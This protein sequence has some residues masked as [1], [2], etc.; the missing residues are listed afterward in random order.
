MLAKKEMPSVKIKKSERTKAAI[1]EAA[2]QLFAAQGYDR[3]TIREVAAA[4]EI[5]PALVMRYFGSKEELF[6][7]VAEPDLR[8]PDLTNVD[9]RD[10]GESLVRHFL[11]LWEGEDSGGGMP[12]LLRSAASNDAAAERLKQMFVKQVMPAIAAG[13]A[14]ETAA[15]RAGL[16]SSQLLGLAMTR[17]IFKL[18]PVVAMDH[19]TIVRQVGATVQRYIDLQ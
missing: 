4:A 9:H 7:S 5:D 3:T 18:P 6:G 17:Y 12:V 16:V 2:Q 8:L 10:I 15:L 19:A 1:A 13:G 14:S 11:E